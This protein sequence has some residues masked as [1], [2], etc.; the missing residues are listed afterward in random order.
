VR[1]SPAVRG[2]PPP[3]IDQGETVTVVPHG[4]RCGIVVWHTIL[5]FDGRPGECQPRHMSWWLLCLSRAASRVVMLVFLPG[6]HQYTSSRV[7]LTGDPELHS[8][9]CG[10]VPSTQAL[11]VLVMAS[12]CPGWQHSTGD[13]R[14]GSEVTKK[15][16]SA[17]LAS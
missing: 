10:G 2:V 6:H 16:C 12:Q 15:M 14:T 11:T 3:F 5:R 17:C 13:G 4:F 1:S 8:G 7:R 9:R